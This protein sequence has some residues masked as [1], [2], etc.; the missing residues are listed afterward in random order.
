[1]KDEDCARRKSSAQVSRLKCTWLDPACRISQVLAERLVKDCAYAFLS[2][3]PRPAPGHAARLSGGP[4]GWQVEF[5]ANKFL[6][7]RAFE[8]ARAVI[9]AAYGDIEACKDVLNQELFI[10][11]KAAVASSVSDYKDDEIKYP[12]EAGFLRFGNNGILVSQAVSFLRRE[13]KILPHLKG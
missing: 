4:H 7:G 2:T 10:N 1:M 13:S 9:N 12:I 3:N 11:L 6:A 8:K 5:G